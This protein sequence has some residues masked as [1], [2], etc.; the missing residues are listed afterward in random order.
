MT[1]TTRAAYVKKYYRFSIRE[2]TV[3]DPGPGE[4]QLQI[5]ACSICGTD[6]SI[7]GKTAKQWS[8]FG[9]EVS[10]VV[11]AVG[12]GVTRFKPGD[13]V[14]LDSSAPCG[15]CELCR[16]G[17]PMECTDIQSYWDKFMGFADYMVA[18]Q[19]QVFPAGDLPATSACLAEPTAVSIDLAAV[20]DVGPGDRVLI[21]GPGPLGLLAIPECRRRGV[22]RLW[23]AGRSHSVA[24][25][26]A[27]T[28]LGAEPIC[29]DKTDLARYDFGPRGV[30][31]ILLVAPPTEIPLA[32]RVGADGC[33][34][35]YIG[36][37]WDRSGTI[38]LDADTF[39]FR[40]QQLRASMARPGTRAAEALELLGSGLFDPRVVISGAFPLERIAEAMVRNRDDKAHAKKLVMVNPACAWK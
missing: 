35:S 24:R 10:G 20:A 27:A 40:R 21:V 8:L 15:Q 26:E 17:F 9:H 1:L 38:K 39:H 11:T 25:M 37:S 13:H 2:R 36:I 6:L 23:M 12:S 7:A 4:V 33:I 30:N 34:I 32:A 3:P 28:Q 22:A 18:P 5:A 31:K 29:V 19:Q 14:A 16:A